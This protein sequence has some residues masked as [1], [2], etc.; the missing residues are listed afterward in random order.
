M[1][2]QSARGE[3]GRVFLGR[4]VVVIP[5]EVRGIKLR[6]FVQ[7]V[8]D[9]DET[10]DMDAIRVVRNIDEANKRGGNRVARKEV[11]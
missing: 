4:K 3:A 2:V 7:P 5:G 11:M 9:F 6:E 1:H 10:E 8:R